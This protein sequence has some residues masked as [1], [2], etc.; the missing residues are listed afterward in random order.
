ML[1]HVYSS[2]IC[3]SQKLGKKTAVLKQENGYR[4]C[5]ILTQSSTTQPLNQRLHEICR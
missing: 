1:H 5:G 2:L 4:K 3:N